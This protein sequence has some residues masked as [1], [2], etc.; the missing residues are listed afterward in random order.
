MSWEESTDYADYMKG[1]VK[2]HD[3]TQREYA[4]SFIANPCYL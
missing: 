2:T 4:P 3:T 1:R